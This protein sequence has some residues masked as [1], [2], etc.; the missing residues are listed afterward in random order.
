MPPWL[1]IPWHSHLA[2]LGKVLSRTVLKVPVVMIKCT[3]FLRHLALA[4]RLPEGVDMVEELQ[5]FTVTESAKL[6]RGL[7]LST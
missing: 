2:F 7:G 3:H 6:Q 4:A 1:E 5:A